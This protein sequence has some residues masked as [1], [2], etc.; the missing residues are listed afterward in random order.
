MSSGAGYEI[1]VPESVE[2]ELERL[3]PGAWGPVLDALDVLAA[4]PSLGVRVM[5]G[6]GPGPMSYLVVVERLPLV[7]RL[8]IGYRFGAGERTLVLTGVVYAQDDDET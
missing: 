7:F 6:E 4:D 8:A 5:P 1:V 2:A 3:A